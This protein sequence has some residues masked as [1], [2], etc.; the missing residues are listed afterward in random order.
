LQGLGADRNSYLLPQVVGETSGMRGR[1]PPVIHRVETLTTSSRVGF[2]LVF[3]TRAFQFAIP[4]NVRS[5][6]WLHENMSMF[7]ATVNRDR[8]DGETRI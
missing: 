7:D 5:G 3:R 6:V 8:A 2:D 1:E 4:W